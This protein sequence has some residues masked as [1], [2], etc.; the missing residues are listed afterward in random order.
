MKYSTGEN[1]RSTITS[2]VTLNKNPDDFSSGFLW[3]HFRESNSGPL[4]YESIALPAELKWPGGERHSLVDF[5]LVSSQTRST[6]HEYVSRDLLDTHP[7]SPQILTFSYIPEVTF[8]GA[9]DGN[10]TRDLLLG[11]QTFYH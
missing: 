1:G 2:W 11:K 9:G 8:Y 4:L 7:N 3:S 10:R 5:G 6:Y